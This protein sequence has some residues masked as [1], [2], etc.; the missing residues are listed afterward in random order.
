[1]FL[2]FKPKLCKYLIRVLNNEPSIPKLDYTILLNNKDLVLLLENYEYFSVFKKNTVQTYELIVKE[3]SK[4]YIET[5]ECQGK[6]SLKATTNYKTMMY[7]TYDI[8]F[9]QLNDYF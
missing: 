2:S 9:N 7:G 6:V 1:M 5:Q 4:L 3:R 8:E